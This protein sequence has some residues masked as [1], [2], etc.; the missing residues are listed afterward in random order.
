VEVLYQTWSSTSEAMALA[1][2]TLMRTRLDINNAFKHYV[3]PM[4]QTID[5]NKPILSAD[6]IR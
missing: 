4:T 5:K 1:G 3:K 2:Y 6:I